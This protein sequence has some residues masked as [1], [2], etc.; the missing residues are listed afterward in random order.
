MAPEDLPVEPAPIVDF[1]RRI[2]LVTPLV[3]RFEIMLAPITPPPIIIASHVSV[4]IQSSLYG[5]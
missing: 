2:V 4:I 5:P 1:Y 3:A